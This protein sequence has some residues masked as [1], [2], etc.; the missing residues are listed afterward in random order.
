LGGKFL[1]TVTYQRVLTDEASAVICAY[2]SRQCAL[3]GFAGHTEQANIR[4][5]PDLIE[6]GGIPKSAR[7]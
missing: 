7:I 3:E 5:A 6:S 2:C 1:K 4:A